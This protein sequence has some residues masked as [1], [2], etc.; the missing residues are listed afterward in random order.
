MINP[1]R[2][3]RKFESHEDKIEVLKELKLV[4]PKANDIKTLYYKGAYTE[5]AVECDVVGI[6]DNNEIILDI[7]G[8]LH[9]IHPDYLL[10][11]QKKERFIIVD[12]ETP[13]SFK[14]ADGIREVAAIVVEDYRVIDSLHLAIINDEEQY[15][16]GYGDGLDAIEENEEL[17]SKFK[18]LVKKYKCPLVAHNASFDRNFL[19]YWGWVEDNQE[20]YCSMNTIKIKETLPS[21]KLVYLLEHYNIKKGQAHNALQDVLD[22]LELL[23]VI[24]PERWSALSIPTSSSAIKKHN[25]ESKDSN[26]ASAPAN[27]FKKFAKDKEKVAEEKEMIEFAKNNLIKDIFNKK[28]IVFTG[29]MSKSRGEMRATAI[30][31]GADSPTSISGKTNMLVIGE[32]A[33]KSKLEKAK[34]LG[35]DIITEKEFWDIINN[36]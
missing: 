17:K 28:K 7:N 8:E 29:D 24:K 26:E 19:R 9:S 21:Y 35:I 1:K 27:R 36:N 30:R 33:G 13:R 5:N 10:D 34:N 20:F 25:K 31:Y 18:A 6:V 16:N 3:W 4:S 14:P 2:E 32:E 15:K 11:M 12:I 22:L 23:K